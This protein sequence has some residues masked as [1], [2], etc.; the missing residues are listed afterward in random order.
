MKFLS[1]DLA[2]LENVI[3]KFY[4][5]I[6]LSLIG[7]L[8]EILGVGLIVPFVIIITDINVM[9]SNEYIQNFTNHFNI[10]TREV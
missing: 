8:F 1:T 10:N 4:F 2:P 7:P 3:E 5:I 6:F 9:N